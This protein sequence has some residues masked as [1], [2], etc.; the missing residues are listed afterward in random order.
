MANLQLKF[1]LVSLPLIYSM[2]LLILD[3]YD[4]FTYNLFHYAQQLCADVSVVKNDE[5]SLAEVNQFS[6]IIISPGP[7]L[8][9]DAGISMHILETYA[10]HK[11]ILGV[12]LGF[13]AL[14]L[15]A[16]GKLY[17]QQQVAHGL[18]RL[19]KRENDSWLLQG[20]APSFK[21]GLY[22][23]WAVN[24]TAV[25]DFKPTAYLENHTLMAFEHQTLPLAGM[26][27]HPESIMTDDGLKMI[28]N[29]MKR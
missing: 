22:H 27:F 2:R 26:Q 9:K 16:G 18:S 14:A 6:H 15:W 20:V 13:Q 7:G 24:L 11:S 12:C 1:F 21:V 28:E 29:W 23:S 19:A 8:P 3:N 5:I 25:N 10:R 4:S 17:N